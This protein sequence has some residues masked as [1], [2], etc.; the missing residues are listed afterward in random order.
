M[1]SKSGDGVSLR[2][3]NIKRGMERAV[4][5]PP[6]YRNT[7]RKGVL[8]KRYRTILDSN[9]NIGLDPCRYRR[10]RRHR[11]SL[12]SHPLKNHPPIRQ[13]R[14]QLVIA[15]VVLLERL[16]YSSHTETSVVMMYVIGERGRDLLRIHHGRLPGLCIARSI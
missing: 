11:A 12:T 10:V 9:S 1:A 4:K 3:I 15:W 14:H 13:T 5:R 8:P 2:P 16:R 6:D 7:S